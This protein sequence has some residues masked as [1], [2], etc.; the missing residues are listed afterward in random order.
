[1]RGQVIEA[2]IVIAVLLLTTIAASLVA[3]YY[4]LRYESVNA[5]LFKSDAVA[6]DRAN[7]IQT[8]QIRIE[9]MKDRK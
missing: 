3:G 5:Q 1:M 4:L 9:M 7:Q 6:T 8:L 2:G